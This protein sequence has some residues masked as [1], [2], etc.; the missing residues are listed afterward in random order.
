M[1]I[2]L[3]GGIGS[4]KS[5]VSH[6]FVARGAKLVDA[7]A[8][9]REVVEFGSPILAEV[10]A[11]FGEEILHP[12]GRLNREQLGNLVFQNPALKKQLENILHPPIRQLIRTRMN[13]FESADP[14][15]LVVVDIPL[16][17]ESKLESMFEHVVVVYVPEEVQITRLIARE[18]WS[19]DVAKRRIATQMPIEDKRL[20]ADTVIENQFSLEQ[21]ANQ[22][23]ALMTKWGVHR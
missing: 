4:G 23:D 13:E 8:I 3:T 1:I 6:L 9:A 2:G 12:D 10:V 15:G 18:G 11:A 21:T 22:V 14:E 16:L 17:F 5:T 19:E 7:D 20:R